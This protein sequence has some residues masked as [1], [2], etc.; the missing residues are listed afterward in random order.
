[1]NKRLSRMAVLGVL[2]AT[3]AFAVE[4]VFLD[5]SQ[6]CSAGTCARA[7]DPSTATEGMYLG[8]ISHFRV[9]ICAASGQT[10]SGAGTLQAWRYDTR[11]GIWERNNDLD[12]T[13]DGSGKRCQAFPD[14]TVGVHNADRVLFAASGVT[15]SGGSAVDVRVEGQVGLFR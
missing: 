9:S 4:A 10:L 2:I 1:M 5:E 15:V 3:A 14:F 13:V 12:Q 8:D 7:S 6:A 11:N